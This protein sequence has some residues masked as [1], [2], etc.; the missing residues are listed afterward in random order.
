MSSQPITQPIYSFVE[1]C[2]ECSLS[3]DFTEYCVNSTIIKREGDIII[4]KLICPYCSM[5]TSVKYDKIKDE[6][7]IHCIMDD[8]DN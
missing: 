7:F 4:Y 1:S 5:K 8:L 2:S 3:F 6:E